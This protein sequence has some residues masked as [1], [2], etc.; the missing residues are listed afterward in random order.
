MAEVAAGAFLS[1]FFQ[2]LFERMDS[3][4]I[5]HFLKGQKLDHGLLKKLKI[6]MITVNGLLDQAE[7]KQIIM[8]AIKEWLNELKDAVY[9]AD[10]LLDDIS[11]Q[12]LRSKLETG[13]SRQKVC[14]IF[15]SH[16]RRRR[17]R[18]HHIEIQE[19]VNAKLGE[20]LGLLEHLVKQMD[21]LGLSMRKGIGE[22]P[23]SQKT[24]TI[25][26]PDDA[27]GIYGREKDKKAIMKS[28]KS[29]DVGVICI[30]G[31]GGIGKTTLAQLVYNENEVN[32][33]FDLKA[34]VCVSEEFDVSKI[35]KD[36]LKEV[37]GENC[38]AKNELCSELKEKLDGKKFLLV[39]DDVWNDK[40]SD[41]ATLRESLQ[42]RAPGSK[43]LITTR[44]ESTSFV[45]HSR[46]VV[47]HL[48]NL[49][50]DDCWFLFAKHAFN[51]GSSS[52]HSD[53]KKIGREI[54]K[55]CKGVPLAAKTI[56]TVL[57]FKRDVVEWEK[58]LESSMWNLV[59]DDI[60]PALQLSYHCLPSHLKRCFAYCA[61]FPKGF[62]FYRKLLIDL[63]MAEGFLLHSAGS[64]KEMEF[65]GNE[66][67]ND[68]VSRSFFQQSSRNKSCFVMHDLIHDLATFISGDFCSSVEGNRLPKLP[69]RTR[70]L[71]HLIT[72]FGSYDE[73]GRI[74]EGLPLRTFFYMKLQKLADHFD[75]CQNLVKLPTNMGRLINLRCLDI[76]ETKLKKMPPQMGNLKE[77]RILT[78]FIMGKRVGSSIKELRE[79]H[80]IR[81]EVRIE[82]LQNVVNVQDAYEANLSFKHHLQKLELKWSG[83]V[84]D[85]EHTN[86]VLENLKPSWSLESLCIVGY[87]GTAFPRWTGDAIF[88]KLL[89][90]KLDKCK[91]CSQL[92]LLGQLPSL[93]DLSITAFDQVTSVGPEFYGR[94]SSMP[95]GSLKVLRFE[96]MPLWNFW[97]DKDGAFPL[98]LDLHII[99][100]PN[101]TKALPNHL[102][103]LTKLLIK[104]CQK[105]VDALPR[106]PVLSEVTL[107]DNSRRVVF[108]EL[109]SG[110]CHL[111]VDG[112]H[113]L[114]FLEQMKDLSTLLEDIEISNDNSLRCF[115]LMLF[116][117]L[118]RVQ[119]SGCL[120]LESFSAAEAY[121]NPI[122]STFLA[123][124]CSNFPPIQEFHICDCPKLPVV[125]M[126]MPPTIQN[127]SLHNQTGSMQV[128]KLSS[129][130]HSLLVDKL[131]LL[132][133]IYKKHL[134]GV[135]NT[136][137]EITVT[138]CN[139]LKYFLLKSFP[140]L[141][142]LVIKQ[143]PNMESFSAPDEATLGDFRSC[144]SLEMRKH[145]HLDSMLGSSPNFPQLEN[146]CIIDCQQL[147]L[148]SVPS[149]PTIQKLT[150]VDESR[151]VKLEKW[152]T[153][154][155][156]SLHVGK[157][158]SPEDIEMWLMSGVCS[159]VAEITIEDCDSLSYIP[160]FPNIE[161]LNIRRCPNFTS[162]SASEAI[163]EEATSLSLLA[164]KECPN[165]ASFPE[166][167]LRAPY[168]TELYLWDCIN[169]NALHDHIKAFFPKLVV[170]KIGR[171]PEFKSFPK[172][173]LPT[174]LQSLEIQSCSKLSFVPS[175]MESN[176]IEDDEEFVPEESLLPS[177]L[178]HL[179]IR[180]LPNLK[181]VDYKG[182]KHLADLEIGD[183]P[184]LH[185]MPECMQTLLPSLVKLKIYNC[186]GLESF[187]DA[188]LLEKLEL[189]DIRDCN[190]LIAGLIRC[191]LHIL[192]SLTRF[193][194]AGYNDLESFPEETLLPSG[195]THLQIQ[196]LKMLKSLQLQHLTS[197]RK[198]EIRD[199][200]ELQYLPGERLPSSLSSLSISGCPLLKQGCTGKDSRIW[201]KISHIPSIWIDYIPL[202]EM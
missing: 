196:G 3:S 21:A 89:S 49:T 7:E 140:R 104:G 142:S 129:G 15:S 55:K 75:K 81:G 76:R 36:I 64:G 31:I 123:R 120:N 172:G 78:N 102:P 24:P 191:N 190:K 53:L 192:P 164:I 126:P 17:R 128:H 197:L 79:L 131:D 109:T 84:K 77:L 182:L 180:D 52:E 34:W 94:S 168:L 85:S 43:I 12:I 107:E 113:S 155:L 138:G 174:K 44:I 166:E 121:G 145:M 62:E 143:C 183:C 152:S 100:C 4:E 63:W 201:V 122:S 48:N 134:H 125:S 59:S 150:L 175:F 26:K 137:E 139:V 108:A 28:L 148:L 114:N 73:L 141:K 154:G 149:A 22:K 105:L 106:A 51:D 132:E 117:K 87:G 56:G 74:N 9:E 185:F 198:L 70:H 90:L 194:V 177:T 116:S 57:R 188:S 110:P 83:E 80:H 158:H 96:D 161:S 6:T 181:S 111:Q 92:P 173:G 200:P 54:V 133:E 162:F 39:M 169:L 23:S 195:L 42:T 193:T 101:L 187:L 38:D 118:K 40:Y 153:S 115:P 29:D 67:F 16:R 47:Y 18:H 68:L 146:I 58:V 35:M 19:E 184:I 119:L 65:L 151:D 127:M 69:L 30:M 14:K 61:I 10:D 199:C 170:L 1:S 41:W 160:L 171:C 50:D 93:Q 130:L 37:T 176:N 60:L 156:Y 71:S 95:F 136:F 112:F 202:S 2:F 5:V 11:Y 189:L 13:S 167:G 165:L 178:T 157:F 20:I 98:L 32:K 99:N 25:S 186:P 88:S 8:P 103:S 72:H 179:K 147:P 33:W 159:N 91:N 27:Y 135:F 66:Y 86:R 97:T 46:S 82:N 45:I 124:T 144:M 163:H